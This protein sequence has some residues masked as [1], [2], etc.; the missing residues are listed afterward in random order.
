MCLTFREFVAAV[1]AALALVCGYAV[2]FEANGPAA[3]WTTAAM[4]AIFAAVA[5]GALAWEEAPPKR[6]TGKRRDD[7]GQE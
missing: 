7:H 5:V 2:A 6:I 1:Y 4:G 3:I